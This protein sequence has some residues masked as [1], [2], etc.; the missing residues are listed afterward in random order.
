MARAAA[1]FYGDPTEQLQVVGITGT[2]GKT[3]TAWLVRAMLEA[4]GIQTGLLGTVSSIV[5]GETRPV[6]RTTPEA[7]DLQR[8]LRGD[9]RRRRRGLRDG[10]LLARARAAAR[11]G[12]PLRG[13]GLHQPQPGPPRLPSRHGGLLPGQAATVRDGPRHA[14]GERRRSLRP[15]ARRRVR[16]HADLRHRRAGGCA[17]ARRAQRP[18]G[19]GLHPAHARRRVAGPARAAGPLQRPQRAGGV[20]GGARA[21]RRAGAAARDA[22]RAA[23]RAR[24]LRARRRGPGL[25]GRR[26]LRAQAGRARE[27]PALGA[28]GRPRIA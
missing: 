24:P 14:G 4:A 11:R 7:I 12:H 22:R 26:R 27:R 23:A 15:A 20:G 8:T 5:A 9:A 1:R 13:R 21:R 10:D 2:N 17:G 19:L 16:R 18:R 6:E 3:T 25:R 28:R